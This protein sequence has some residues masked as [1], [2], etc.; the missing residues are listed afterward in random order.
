[1]HEIRI[2][3]GPPHFGS[4]DR[5]PLVGADQCQSAQVDRGPGEADKGHDIEL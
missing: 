5:P 3:C 4:E 1:M 2:D